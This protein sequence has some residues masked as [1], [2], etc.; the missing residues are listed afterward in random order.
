MMI[1][2]KIP[3][4]FLCASAA[5]FIS[6]DVSAQDTV[7]GQYNPTAP[8]AEEAPSVAPVPRVFS[9]KIEHSR[10]QALAVDEIYQNLKIGLWNY[11]Q[12]DFA[13][14]AILMDKLK[15]EN[16]RTTRHKAEFQR[17][18]KAAM[19]NLNKNYKDMKQQVTDAQGKFDKAIVGVTSVEE[20]QLRGLWK[21]KIAE[22]EGEMAEYFK[23]QHGYLLQY[24]NLVGFILS[25]S[26]SFYYDK[27]SGALRFFDITDYT[28]FASS[29]DKLNASS[30]K[31]KA[32]LDKVL[33]NADFLR[34]RE[35]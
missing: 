8:R 20:E 23:M 30:R 28:Y 4:L 3:V 16:F 25:K 21:E 17:E 33:P 13:Q 31:Q 32:F 26:G 2:K 27:D 29:I 22:F 6:A 15:L 1:C 12:S 19:A 24:R 35:E 11:G 14:Q 7:R 10:I 9:S 5:L 18:M 34:K